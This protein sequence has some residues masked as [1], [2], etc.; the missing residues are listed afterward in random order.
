MPLRVPRLIG[1][2]KR[3]GTLKSSKDVYVREKELVNVRKRR[4]K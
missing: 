3:S 2:N 1:T 4:L